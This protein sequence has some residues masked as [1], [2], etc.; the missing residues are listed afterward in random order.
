MHMRKPA[1]TARDSTG[2]LF[3]PVQSV[4]GINTELSVRDGIGRLWADPMLVAAVR[5]GG[6]YTSGRCVLSTARLG[7][8]LW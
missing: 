2:F 3:L 4:R 8:N 1:S 6:L 5:E 7:A